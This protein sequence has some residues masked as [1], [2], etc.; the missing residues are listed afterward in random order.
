MLGKNRLAVGCLTTLIFISPSLAQ[1]Q[2]FSCLDNIDPVNRV[3]DASICLTSVVK[4]LTSGNFVPAVTVSAVPKGTIIAWYASQGPV[5]AG[6]AV[7]DGSSGTPD[8]RNR[9][10]QGVGS[11]AD[12][13][14][15]PNGSATHF[16]EAQISTI[17]PKLKGEVTLVTN[18]GGDDVPVTRPSHQHY[19]TV[20][21]AS[22]I[23]PNY[24]LVF[25]MKL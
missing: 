4:T 17:D 5:P 18:E 3:G 25:L 12:S 7:C 10:I 24:R 22:S 6:W 20:A 11:I 19:A 15:D 14:E 16:H 23:P 21:P 13:G 1:E 8:L 9:F 2:K